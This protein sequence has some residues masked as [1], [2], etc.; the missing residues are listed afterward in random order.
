MSIEMIII[1]KAVIFEHLKLVQ[2][3]NLKCDDHA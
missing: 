2:S 3:I 1:N